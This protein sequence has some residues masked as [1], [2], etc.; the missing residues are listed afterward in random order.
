MQ[1][2]PFTVRG[3]ERKPER[4]QPPQLYDLTELQRDMNR[5]YGLSADAT[6]KAAQSL[7]EAKL[8][9]YPRT[10]SRYLGA[11]MKGEDPGH[12]GRPPGRSSRP[13][14]ASWT[15][16]ALAFTGRII[17]DAKVS[18]HHAIIPTGKR[19]GALSPA[20]QK[21]FDAVVTRLIAAFYP[22]CVKEVTT[23]SG[24]LERGAV[25][26]QGRAGAR[27]GLDGALSPQA[28]DDQKDD[29][30]E[31]PEFRPGESGPHEPSVRR[32][33]DHAAEAL[34]RGEPARGDGDGRQA[35]RRRGSSRR[36]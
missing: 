15:S 34:H 9:S 29:E 1:G 27:A 21:V 31:L 7:Y 24:R 13:R 8:I 25:P 4:V 3:V 12:P 2:H 23:V 5:R 16:N 26:G 22:A 33:R 35:R 32:G 19:P 11:D 18:D 17:N 36:R 10:D 30:Q 20:A 14:S 28:Q 6:L